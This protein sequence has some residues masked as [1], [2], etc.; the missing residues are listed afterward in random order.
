MKT[1]LA[2]FAVLL[3]GWGSA[4]AARAQQAAVA[5]LLKTGDEMIRSVARLRSLEPKGPI[6][7][8]VKSREE[9]S[10][11]LN[12]RVQAEYEP[13]TIEREGR[14][15]RKL[16][17]IPAAMDYRGFVIR[18][19]T[20]QVGG[21]YDSERKTFFIASWLPVE[22]QKPVMIHELTH[23]LQDQHFGI[24]AKIKEN[25]SLNSDDRMLALQAVMEGDAMVVMLQYLLEPAK[26]HFSQ[27]PDLSVIMQAQMASMQA[28]FPVFKESP[29]YL[30]ETLLF[31][32][33]YG[34][35]F[36]QHGWTRSPSWGAI[37]RI[38]ADMPVSTE[39]I[40]HP[41]KYFGERDLPKPVRT[42]DLVTALGAS[43]KPAVKNVLGE[44]TLGL[45]MSLH[46]T[47]ERSRR[48]AAGWGGDEVLLLE[49]AE[50][51]DAVVLSTTWDTPEDA[52]NFYT[53]MDEWFRRR[54]PKA[55]RSGETPEGFSL[56]DNGE[57]YW[58]R[59]NGNAIRIIFGL[60]EADGKAL[61]LV[62]SR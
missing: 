25:R 34:A 48:A 52:E 35:S 20:E 9:I 8:G 31:P 10:K 62:E 5:D 4:T 41:E 27:L 23:A 29:A 30:K 53:S 56:V 57:F 16:G 3:A 43:W 50:G 38:Y 37:D 33:G 32:Y 47:E 55:Q 39:Q 14:I 59:K 46:L 2:L 60:P 21:F 6:E 26:R 61:K 17:M 24:S 11:F 45:L 19:L 58:M 51:R 7:K 42:D 44:F 40:M 54:F 36:I 49:N 1:Y 28:Q 13:G 12:E 22:E 18:L 15:L